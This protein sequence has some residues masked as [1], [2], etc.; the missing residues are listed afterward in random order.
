LYGDE[1]L[2]RVKRVLGLFQRH[3]GGEVGAG[4]NLNLSGHSWA[5]IYILIYFIYSALIQVLLCCLSA[6]EYPLDCASEANQGQVFLKKIDSVHYFEPA[7][8]RKA[9]IRRFLLEY[10]K[11]LGQ[12]GFKRAHIYA[13]PPT[14]GKPYFFKSRVSGAAF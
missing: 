3:P 5:P 8:H 4:I 11:A 2:G 14:A 13:D 12:A 1:P 6:D 9:C 10:L 7:A